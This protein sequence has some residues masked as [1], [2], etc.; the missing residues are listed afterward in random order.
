MSCLRI[1]ALQAKPGRE[2]HG[3]RLATGGARWR[4]DSQH[5]VE[6][7]DGDD[8]RQNSSERPRHGCPLVMVS[9]CDAANARDLLL[10][11]A[12]GCISNS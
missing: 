8:A 12:D 9:L 2:A 10:T 5:E 3:V 1:G 7:K 4:R 11:A 6:D